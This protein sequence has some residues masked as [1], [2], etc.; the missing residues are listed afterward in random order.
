MDQLCKL[1]EV[2]CSLSFKRHPRTKEHRRAEQRSHAVEVMDEDMNIVD[3]DLS[4]DTIP[5]SPAT[6]AFSEKTSI[7]T[8]EVFRYAYWPRFSQPLTKG[9]GMHFTL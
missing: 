8:Y 7:V 9:L 2:D 5:I 3:D 4:T 1:L 6:E